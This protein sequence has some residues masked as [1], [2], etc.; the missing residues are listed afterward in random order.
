MAP[1]T[2]ALNVAI[3]ILMVGSIIELSFISSMVGWLHRRAGRDFDINYN[4]STFPL[5]GKPLGLLVDQG[6][7]SNGAA[8]TAF[9]LIGMGGILAL[10]LRSRATRTSSILSRIGMFWYYFWLAMTVPSI[11]LTLAALIYTLVLTNNHDGQII[12]IAIAATLDNRPYPNYVAY[13]LDEW[14]PENWFGAVLQLPLTHNSDAGTI[15][16][17]LRVMR[18]WRWNLIPM[19]IIGLAVCLIGM[20]E[21][22][23]RR[24]DVSSKMTVQEKRLSA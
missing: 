17:H 1:L 7:T 16:E 3:G 22:W 8:G 20:A 10:W 2:L 12:D 24:R 19:F 15:R 11:L 14:T 18:G 21:A 6:H 9:V 13:P 5:H 23:S 4:G